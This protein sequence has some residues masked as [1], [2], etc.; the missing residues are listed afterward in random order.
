[1]TEN[2]T[3]QTGVEQKLAK[4]GSRKLLALDS[5]GIRGLI[6]IEVL[7]EMERTLRDLFKAPDDF[8]LADYFDYIGGTS[9]GA[10]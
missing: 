5:G 4:A 1:M 10:I 7:A 2:L 6:S 8:V 9:V 3:A